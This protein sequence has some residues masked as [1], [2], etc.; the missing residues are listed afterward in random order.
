MEISIEGSI[1]SGKSSLIDGL[2]EILG[3]STELEPVDEWTPLLQRYYQKPERWGFAMQTRI[4]TSFMS[5]PKCTGL[6]LIERS[7]V[8]CRYVFGEL[9][10]EEGI[11]DDQEW[12]LFQQLYDKSKQQLDVPKA[13]IFVDTPAGICFERATKRGR[14]A[15]SPLTLDYLKKLEAKYHDFVAQNAH[16]EVVYCIDGTKSADEVL[17]EAVNCVVDATSII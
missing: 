1:G 6:K 16:F 5:R 11:L 8:S 2:K 3:C 12:H 7:P 9:L 13:C 14:E 15:E 17:K 10:H 4:L